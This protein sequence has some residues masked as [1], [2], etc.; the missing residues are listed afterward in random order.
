[1]IF[2]CDS[3][4]Q[5]AQSFISPVLVPGCLAVDATA[6]NGQ[7]TLFLA[8]GVGE[9]G[10]VFAFDI[11]ARALEKTREQLAGAGLLDRVTL[12]AVDHREM[13]AYVPG[14]VKAVMFNLGYLPGGDHRIITRPDSTLEALEAA[15]S[16]LAAG[17]RIS[18]VVYTGHPGAMEELKAVEDF[19]RDL[20]PHQYAVVRLSFWNRSSRAPVVIL[21]EKAGA[22]K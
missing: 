7:D 10:R 22:G 18:L 21:L 8:R 9:Q 11:Q 6:G 1:M 5:W 19:T 16:L 15:L 13:S 20:S 14:G 3:A 2:K 12:L 17:G 4:V